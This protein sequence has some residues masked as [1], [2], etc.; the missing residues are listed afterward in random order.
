M[1]IFLNILKWILILALVVQLTLTFSLFSSNYEISSTRTLQVVRDISILLV[2]I[3]GVI[4]WKRKV[5]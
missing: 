3:G 1:K 4:Y 2:L 5:K